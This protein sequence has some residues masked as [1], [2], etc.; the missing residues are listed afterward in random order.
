MILDPA[1]VA[2]ALTYSVEALKNSITNA[3]VTYTYAVD[4][5]ALALFAVIFLVV[6]TFILK[7]R[8]S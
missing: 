1:I 7:K 4:I 5:G 8:I 6:A 2:R 3:A